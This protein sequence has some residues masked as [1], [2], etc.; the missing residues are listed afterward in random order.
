MSK[1]DGKVK[2]A[3]VAL[4]FVLP[5]IE[6]PGSFGRV[7]YEAELDLKTQE[8]SGTITLSF[9]RQGDLESGDPVNNPGPAYEK[10][11]F[12]GTRVTVP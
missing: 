7:D 9:S 6:Q 11:L 10:F 2:A 8:I 3:A 12:S 5:S 1:L 4:T